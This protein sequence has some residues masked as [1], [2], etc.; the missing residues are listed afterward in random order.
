MR[1]PQH[2]RACAR[3]GASAVHAPTTPAAVVA[4][5]RRGARALCGACHRS[6]ARC[7]APRD[8]RHAAPSELCRPC[9]AAM[10]RDVQRLVLDPETRGDL[11]RHL[12]GHAGLAPLLTALQGAAA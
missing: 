8:T 7:G 11:V 12:E 4:I 9:C 3:C 1:Y 10:L 6:C 2:A 5:R